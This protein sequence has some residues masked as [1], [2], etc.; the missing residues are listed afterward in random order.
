MHC[1]EWRTHPLL[2]PILNCLQAD[3]L[4]KTKIIVFSKNWLLCL[5]KCLFLLYIMF[6]L[7]LCTFLHHIQ[8]RYALCALLLNFHVLM[9][10]Y[11]T[12]HKTRLFLNFLRGIYIPLK[13]LPSNNKNIS[14]LYNN[15]THIWIFMCLSFTTQ[16][17]T[18]RR[19]HYITKNKTV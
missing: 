8:I 12:K 15:L 17:K 16:R 3:F 1:S 4:H 7:N 13:K 14:F 19:E 18:E 9:I 2:E 11:L 5:K 6:M 10:Q